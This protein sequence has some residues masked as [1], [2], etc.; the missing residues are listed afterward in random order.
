MDKTSTGFKALTGAVM[1]LL[2]A[3]LVGVVL[4]VI[5]EYPRLTTQNLVDRESKLLLKNEEVLVPKEDAWGKPLEYSYQVDP[6]V[7]VASVRS[8]GRDGMLGTDDD[9]KGVSLDFNKSRI[10]GEWLGTKAK[11]A[12]KG[13]IDGLKEKSKFDTKED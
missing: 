6:K 3:G 13:F 9:I 4:L 8:A 2:I 11:Q 5:H 12:G 10:V 1:V 7:A